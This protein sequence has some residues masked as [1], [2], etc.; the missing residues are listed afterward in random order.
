MGNPGSIVLVSFLFHVTAEQS[1]ADPLGTDFT[2][3]G[4]PKEGGSLANGDFDFEFKLFDTD[5][6]GTQLSGIAALD[7][8]AVIDGRFTV[9]VDFGVNVFNG[10]KRWLEITVRPSADT[11]PNRFVT[12]SPRQGITA[13][14]YA[15]Q[16]RGLFVD[17][18]GLVG[19]GTDTPLTNLYVDGGLEFTPFGIHG[20][21]TAGTGMLFTN[22]ST[23]NI[24]AII[25]GGSS[26]FFDATFVITD[27]LEA[28]LAID[29]TGNI[30]M[31]TTMPTAPLHLN[32]H[33]DPAVLRLETERPELVPPISE[34][35][36]PGLA[37]GL[38]G[39][40]SWANPANALSV[41]GVFA[42][43]TLTIAI[44]GPFN[45]VSEPLEWSNFGFNLPNNAIVTGI[46]MTVTGSSTC[47]CPACSGIFGFCSVQA[48]FQL[49]SGQ[50]TS[51]TRN[52]LLGGLIT[53]PI[54]IDSDD[55]GVTWTPE[56]INAADFTVS[57][58]TQMSIQKTCFQFAQLFPCVCD[59]DTQ[60]DPAIDAV[61]VEVF[62]RDPPPEGLPLDWTMGV[63]KNQ[64]EFKISPTTD[65][66]NSVMTL[67]TD[68]TVGFG[69]KNPMHRVELP[70]VADATGQGRANVWITYSSRAHKQNVEPIDHALEKVEE[71]TGVHFDWN[72]EQGGG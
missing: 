64:Y 55:W 69:V 31:G 59:C 71:L 4:E 10:D 43:T 25:A 60:A 61:T 16:T 44:G 39:G 50:T 32:T 1:I 15:L 57:L 56:M 42:T 40:T 30:G 3:Q 67:K 36:T 11:N 47:S 14:P 22:S 28:R 2:W 13:V 20:D 54:T 38:G 58:T 53:Q 33:F 45:N 37:V 49:S 52:M 24:W 63:A 51:D 29:E 34:T 72:P 66:S 62:Y 26:A 65:L 9:Q 17:D 23:P 35:R 27:G 8:I 21:D 68:G 19:I 46:V 41:D 48:D 5:S 7:D 70:N 12:V 6:G 18:A